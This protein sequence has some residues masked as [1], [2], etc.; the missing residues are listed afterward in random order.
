MNLCA[1]FSQSRLQKYRGIKKHLCSVISPLTNDSI[2]KTDAKDNDFITS[3][4]PFSE[5]IVRLRTELKRNRGE[6]LR[7]PKGHLPPKET[8]R[9]Y[10]EPTSLSKAAPSSRYKDIEWPRRT[11][12]FASEFKVI[13]RSR[14]FDAAM[15]LYHTMKA[16]SGYVFHQSVLTGFSSICHKKEHLSSALEIFNNFTVIGI[17]PNET[18]FM[19]LVRCNSDNGDC[20]IALKLVDEMKLLSLE[21]KL[22]TYHPI[23]EAACKAVDFKSAIMIINQMLDDGVVPHS[24]QFVILLEVAA[25]SGALKEIKNREK[26]DKLLL[27][28]KLHLTDMD[29]TGLERILAVYRGIT[30]LAAREEGIMYSE[31]DTFAANLNTNQNVNVKEKSN[32]NSSSQKLFSGMDFLDEIDD[33]EEKDASDDEKEVEGNLPLDSTNKDKKVDKDTRIDA[34]KILNTAVDAHAKPV[35]PLDARKIRMISRKPTRIVNILN[36]TCSCPNCGGDLIPL[37]LD[38][39]GRERVRQGLINI[40]SAISVQHADSIAVNH[41]PVYVYFYQNKYS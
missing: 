4:N 39:Y 19:S 22:R 25:L 36:G 8:P 37:F 33:T 23:L 17:T 29:M 32:L 24:E 16:D 13:M 28:G 26:I 21:L 7:N 27:S 18:A 41:L 38:S 5:Q 2:T 3:T 35:V 40:A 1:Y 12:A 11:D 6:A 34:P 20:A 30:L 9:S 10:N 31:L 15:D 14:D